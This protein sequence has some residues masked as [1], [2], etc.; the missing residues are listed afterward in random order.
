MKMKSILQIPG[1][2]LSFYIS[3]LEFIFKTMQGMVSL[4]IPA[5]SLSVTLQIEIK[6]KVLLPVL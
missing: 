5:F 2:V 1:H 3:H 6:H 4:C